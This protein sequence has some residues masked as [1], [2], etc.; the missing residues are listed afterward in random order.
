MAYR[1]S[2]LSLSVP[3]MLLLA[4]FT[5]IPVSHSIPFVILHGNAIM[6]IVFLIIHLYLVLE[7][8]QIFIYIMAF[9]IPLWLI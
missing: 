7:K 3:V 9:H 6:Q 4:M 5:S 2:P 8:L 1:L